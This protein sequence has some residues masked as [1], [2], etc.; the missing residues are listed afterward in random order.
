M[1]QPIAPAL[2]LSFSLAVAL[3]P[4]A[5]SAEQVV[6]SLDAT[7]R[8]IL[9]TQVD[10][11]ALVQ[12]PLPLSRFGVPDEMTVLDL[13]VDRQGGRLFLV[14]TRPAPAASGR[15]APAAATADTLYEL[16]VANTEEVVNEHGFPISSL[17]SYHLT[18]FG[19]TIGSENA[20]VVDVEWD[21]EGEELYGVT[22]S[23]GTQPGKLVQIDPETGAVHEIHFVVAG[24][25]GAPDAQL[26]GFTISDGKMKRLASDFGGPTLL[27]QIDLASKVRTV[28]ALVGAPSQK[29]TGVTKLP[30][31]FAGAGRVAAPPRAA[32]TSATAELLASFGSQM[33]T[34][35]ELGNVTVL[36]ELAT[37]T[38]TGT[39][40]HQADGLGFAEVPCAGS[41]TSLCLNGGRFR[42]SV[43]FRTR[44]GTSGDG[45]AVIASD[46]SGQFFFFQ[47]SN[48]E[49]L[50]KVLDG[51]AIN[52]RYWVLASAAT[53]LEL[54]LTLE[55]TLVEGRVAT[56]TNPLGTPAASIQD[57]NGSPFLCD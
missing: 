37:T 31:G 55:D 44:Q 38:A 50:V 7:A 52:G 35:D 29:V 24:N 14:G 25:P 8:R 12:A 32:R 9:V 1:R 39:I 5:S 41:A 47:P 56:Y 23:E 36:G 40:V 16:V 34:V 33:A 20:K 57:V 51:C 28:T 19:P 48:I 46:D 30:A 11:P 4:A 17:T 6:V 15:R 54:V 21:E 13:A 42:A 3:L 45:K 2:T 10:P 53:N 43:R 26:G 22:A 27:E 49:M 18:I